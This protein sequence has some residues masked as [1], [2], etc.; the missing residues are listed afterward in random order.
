[1]RWLMGLFYSTICEVAI[2]KITKCG[3][4]AKIFRRTVKRCP[5]E[6]PLHARFPLNKMD[7]VIGATI[8]TCNLVLAMF[9]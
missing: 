8:T 9:E 2:V 7:Q 3:S 1:V 6:F 4:G 5:A